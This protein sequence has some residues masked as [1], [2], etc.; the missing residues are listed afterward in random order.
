MANSKVRFGILSAANIAR[1]NWKAIQC[2]GNATVVAVAS[3]DPE[4]GRRFV[5]ECQAEVPMETRP[6]V[7]D[8]YEDLLASDSVEAVYLPLPTGLRKEWVLRAAARGKHVICEKPCACTVDDLEEMLEACRQKGVQ[9]MDGVMFMHSRRLSRMKEVLADGKSVGRLKRITSAFTFGSSPDFFSTNI[10]THGLL[11]PLGCLGDLGWYCIR[12]TLWAMNWQM[13]RQVLGR[14][15]ADANRE[16]SP[17][18]VPTDFSGELFFNDG[19]SA[20]FYC[21]FI[22]ENQQWAILSGSRGYLQL[23]DF[24]LPFDGPELTFTVHN[25]EFKPVGCDFRMVPHETHF[26]VDEFSQGH[27]TA[28]EAKLF[29]NFSNQVRSGSLNSFWPEIALKTQKITNA[30]FESAREN[31]QRIDL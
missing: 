21:S 8:S 24:V 10:R 26:R 18:P 17:E 5:D 25:T 29:R 19:V 14:V 27:S 4:R 9:F 7:F 6:S 31:G 1:K 20:S 2:S 28:Q 15:H 3:R 22:S 12:L 30:C 11:E 23:Q 16:G 13:P